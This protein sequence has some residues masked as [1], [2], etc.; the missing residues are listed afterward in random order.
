MYGLTRLSPLNEMTWS[1]YS[2]WQ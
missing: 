2:C 1:L